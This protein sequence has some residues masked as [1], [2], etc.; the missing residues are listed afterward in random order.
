MFSKFFG[1]K[2]S[3]SPKSVAIAAAPTR[4]RAIPIYSALLEQ[5]MR[6]VPEGLS[7]RESSPEFQKHRDGWQAKLLAQ[8]RPADGQPIITSL[9]TPAG[10]VVTFAMPDTGA[11]AALYFSSPAR[12]A[13]Y[14][15]AMGIEG[16][17]G[18]ILA[19]T[20]P[21]F[22]QM[23]R[24]L[25]PSAVT[26]FAFDRC[27]RC[28]EVSVIPA[29]EVT[30]IEQA[31]TVRSA[32]KARE[33]AREQLYFAYALDAA[34]AGHLDE[35]REVA[36]QAA[37]HITLEDPNMHLLIGQLGVALAEPTLTADALTM[38]KVMKADVHAGKLALISEIGAADFE[39]PDGE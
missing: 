37:G 20:L 3:D 10:G 7:E 12:A 34:R 11:H 14:K 4:P 17:P 23:L 33:I 21:G 22:L 24:D 38:L 39:G 9:A 1:K 13:D 25:E 28:S 5:P 27:P 32:Y 2:K 36:L 35:A 8:P 19:L 26:A 6:S 30:T 31:W 29:H 16:E 15:D 18:Q